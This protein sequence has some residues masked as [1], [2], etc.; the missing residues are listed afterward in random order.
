MRSRPTAESVHTHRVVTHHLRHVTDVLVRSRLRCAALVHPLQH[1]RLLGPT[2]AVLNRERGVA[3]LVGVELETDDA[4]PGGSLFVV[5]ELAVVHDE[6][7]AG[8]VKDGG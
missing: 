7:H 4:L 6:D 8:D 5:A 2:K 1:L 3:A